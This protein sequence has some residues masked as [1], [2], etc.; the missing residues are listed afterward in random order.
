MIALIP[1]PTTPILAEYRQKSIKKFPKEKT[2]QVS[3]SS[4][5]TLQG[6]LQLG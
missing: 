5:K 4:E 3:E 6:F 2:L 1:E